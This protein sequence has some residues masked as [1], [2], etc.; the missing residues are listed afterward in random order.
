[1]YKTE[2]FNFILPEELIAQ[3][4]RQDKQETPML[5]WDNG[6]IVDSKIIAL[7]DILRPDDLLIFN[8]AKVINAKFVAN[9]LSNNKE[10][11]FNLDQPKQINDLTIWQALCKPAK[12]VAVTD[13][14]Q[15]SDDFF[16]K[17]LAKNQNG[18]IELEFYF[19]NNK[20]NADFYQSNYHSNNVDLINHQILQAIAKFGNVP[21]PPYIAT[22]E[23]AVNSYQTIFAKD[24]FFKDNSAQNSFVDSNFAVAAPTASLHFTAEIM[25]KLEAKGIEIGYLTLNVGAGT[26][27]PVKAEKIEDHKM[28]YEFF[29]ISEDLANKINKAKAEKRRII[30]VGTT[31][32]RA[33]EASANNFKKNRNNIVNSLD[34]GN[35]GCGK[36]VESFAGNTN[37]FIYPGYDFLVIDGMITNF[38]LP[39]ST[40]LMLV[41]AFT[42]IDEMHKIYAHAIAKK[43]QFY[44]FG[45]SSLLLKNS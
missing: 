8:K 9:N 25:A 16:A 6:K 33:L 22:S 2:T 7:L 44:S 14:L 24:D 15:I 37:I 36:I 26:F 20:N 4:P 10:I 40:L 30:A 39:K 42:S 12:K 23:E 21:L 18:F 35:S 45:D 17:I 34:S 41:S 19:A 27:L 38:H 28:H 29:E 13:V 43:Y 11:S 31:V 5:Y 3:K 1:M 32:V